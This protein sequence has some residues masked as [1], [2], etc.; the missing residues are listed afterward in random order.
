MDN[1]TPQ[2]VIRQKRLQQQKQEEE[3]QKENKL[4]SHPGGFGKRIKPLPEKELE[5]ILKSGLP[6]EKQ[7]AFFENGKP[8]NW[9]MC[10]YGKTK[11]DKNKKTILVFPGDASVE[12]SDANF[13]SKFVESLVGEAQDNNFDLFSFFYDK[14]EEGKRR[15]DFSKQRLN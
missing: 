1:L 8:R 13:Y 15:G 5:R 11:I 10:D 7:Q 2:E 9:E 6:Q 3:I 12:P 14:F 4:N